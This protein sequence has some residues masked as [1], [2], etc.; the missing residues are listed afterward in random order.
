MEVRQSPNLERQGLEAS[1]LSFALGDS[2]SHISSQEKG[3]VNSNFSIKNKEKERKL[4]MR[5][6][7]HIPL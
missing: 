6:H 5:S 1:G 4:K 3:R 7:I 2:N